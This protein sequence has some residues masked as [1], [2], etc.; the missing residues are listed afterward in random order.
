[1][2]NNNPFI[3][4][5]HYVICDICGCQRYRSDCDYT[6]DGFIACHVFN[7]WYPKDPLFMVPPV[8]NDP[9]TLLDVRPE[10][11]LANRKL[12]AGIEHATWTRPVVLARSYLSGKW[13]EMNVTWGRIEE[14]PNYLLT[15]P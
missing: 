8:I 1:M 10:T 5:D 7:C 12:N 3:K 4:G 9:F 2:K 13:N 11:P 14:S 15:P 6:W